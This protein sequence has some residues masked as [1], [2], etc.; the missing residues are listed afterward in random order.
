MTQPELKEIKV[1]LTG[2]DLPQKTD[3]ER[4][5]R[6][7]YLEFIRFVDEWYEKALLRESEKTEA[8]LIIKDSV[9]EIREQIRAIVEIDKTLTVDEKNLRLT[10]L[11][12]KVERVLK[13]VNDTKISPADLQFAS[14]LFA[15][16]LMLQTFEDEPDESI[17]ENINSLAS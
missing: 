16:E 3:L 6:E 1:Y 9:G 10:A 17:I 4:H 8:K 2:H 11:E 7:H 13:G 14:H 12:Q 5:N 15:D